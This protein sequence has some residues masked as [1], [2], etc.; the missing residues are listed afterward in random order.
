MSAFPPCGAQ[1][2]FR[3]TPASAKGVHA[4]EQAGCEQDEALRF[5]RDGD[6]PTNLSAGVQGVM[7]VCVGQSAIES[8]DECG[9]RTGSRSM[10]GAAAGRRGRG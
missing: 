7:D 5:G 8:S 4:P 10:G 3:V 6:Q 1:L 9:L 2:D